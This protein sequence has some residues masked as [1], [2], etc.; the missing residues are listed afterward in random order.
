MFYYLLKDYFDSKSVHRPKLL[1]DLVTFMI[2]VIL[3][4][5]AIDQ[6]LRIVTKF[7][8]WSS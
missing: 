3:G 7:Y 2:A 1:N 8:I 6:G 4:V 5:F